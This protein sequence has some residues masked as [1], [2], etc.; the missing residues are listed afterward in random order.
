[1]TTNTKDHRPDAKP[2]KAIDPAITSKTQPGLG[3]RPASAEPDLQ[4]RINVRRVALVARLREIRADMH[5]DA[6]DA[7]DKLKAKL[8][9]ISHIIKDGVVDGWASLGDSVKNKLERWLAESARYLPTQDGP[10]KIGQS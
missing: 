10:A 5:L 1:M 6:A 4:S 9:E 7:G 3:I 2:D 8:S